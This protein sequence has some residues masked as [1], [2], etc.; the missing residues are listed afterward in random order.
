MNVVTSK[1]ETDIKTVLREKL[2]EKYQS[3]FHPLQMSNGHLDIW[4]NDDIALAFSK[5]E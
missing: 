1:G 2:K 4:S 3:V 5:L